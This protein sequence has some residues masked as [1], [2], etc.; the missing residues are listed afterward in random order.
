L[1]LGDVARE[2]GDEA[3]AVVH[4]RQ[5]LGMQQSLGQQESVLAKTHLDIGLRLDRLGRRDEARHELQRAREAL[6]SATAPLLRR[7]ID[8]ALALVDG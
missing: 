3:G 5:A 7:R 8:E 6:G 2:R 4:Y 1:L